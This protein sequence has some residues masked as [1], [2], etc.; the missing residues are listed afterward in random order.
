MDSEFF[1]SMPE[2]LKAAVFE[3]T[4]YHFQMM[5]QA[6]QNVQMGPGQIAPKGPMGGSK[7]NEKGAKSDEG[8]LMQNDAQMNSEGAV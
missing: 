7:G 3:R 6:A 8:A 4:M 2:P 5:M 1:E